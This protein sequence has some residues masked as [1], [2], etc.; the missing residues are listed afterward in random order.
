[1]YTDN[2]RQD[3]SHM[4][5]GNSYIAVTGYYF[6][7]LYVIHTVHFLT[8]SMF[9]NTKKKPRNIKHIVL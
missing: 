2:L 5:Y 4:H 8:F 7:I 1:M 9:T 6:F 3:I